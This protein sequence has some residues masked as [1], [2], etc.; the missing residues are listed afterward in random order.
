VEIEKVDPALI[1]YLG[2][3]GIP[4]DGDGKAKVRVTGT[5]AAPYLSGVG[6]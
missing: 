1:G 5:L 6:P 3:L 2:P 4:V